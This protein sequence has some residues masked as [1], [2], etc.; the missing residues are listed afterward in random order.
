MAVNA[1][2][3]V[4]PGDPVAKDGLATPAAEAELST[5]KPNQVN[6][7]TS[8]DIVLTVVQR[9]GGQLGFAST[10]IRSDKEVVL[11]AVQQDGHALQYASEALKDDQEVVERAVQQDGHSLVYASSRLK[12][13]RGV[14]GAAVQQ[15]GH[16]LVFASPAF[17][18]DRDLV[19]VGNVWGAAL[20]RF[21]S[22]V[23]HTS[24]T[25]RGWAAYHGKKSLLQVPGC[26]H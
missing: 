7:G 17:R 14:V 21:P 16:A 2:D 4:P 1:P 9:E 8:R 12:A 18:G 22:A 10:A 3:A 15:D 25:Q 6:E 20:Q 23:H 26:V 5:D 24:R 19:F 13:D 11:L